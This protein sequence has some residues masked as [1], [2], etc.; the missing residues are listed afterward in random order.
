[1]PE[2]GTIDEVSEPPSPE[3]RIEDESESGP[4]ALANMLRRSPPQSPSEPNVGSDVISYNGQ[5]SSTSLS[6]S[7]PSNGVSE[8]T[9]LLGALSRRPDSPDSA[10]E[11]DDI[12]S[13]KPKMGHWNSSSGIFAGGIQGT[14]RS[15]RGI[16]SPKTW[17]KKVIFQSVVM[18]PI[19]CLPAVVVGL[20]L[21]I[22]DALSYGV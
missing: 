18:D 7:S 17:D 3:L 4:S 9:P 14:I 8:N 16:A 5:P 22:L 12:E 13:Q 20:L 21:N 15:I 19:H 10:T 1:M 6:Q 11:V 2:A